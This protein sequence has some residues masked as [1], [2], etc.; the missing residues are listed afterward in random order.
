MDCKYYF[1]NCMYNCIETGQV[2]DLKKYNV[3]AKL[4]MIYAHTT[5][6]SDFLLFNE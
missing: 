6:Y 2:L 5:K 1:D 4:D 3:I